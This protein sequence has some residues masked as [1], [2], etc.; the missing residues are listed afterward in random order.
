MTINNEKLSGNSALY[1]GGK[2]SN[3]SLYK[4][5]LVASISQ[6]VINSKLKNII[7]ASSDNTSHCYIHKGDTIV[8]DC[9]T[10]EREIHRTASTAGHQI[11]NPINFLFSIPNTA[12]QTSLQKKIADALVKHSSFV[13]AFRVKACKKIGASPVILLDQGTTNAIYNSFIKE[14]DI[15]VAIPEGQTSYRWI[16]KVYNLD[17][18][19]QVKIDIH[20][21]PYEILPL[22]PDNIKNKIKIDSIFSLQNLYLALNLLAIKSI[23]T[24]PK[25]DVSSDVYKVLEQFLYDTCFATLRKTIETEEDV[26]KSYPAQNLGDEIESI[27]TAPAPSSI[28]PTDISLLASPYYDGNGQP[29]TK[30]NWYTLNYLVM[31]DNHPMPKPTPFDWNWVEPSEETDYDAVLAIRGGALLKPLITLLD[32]QNVQIPLS[33][34]MVM[35]TIRYLAG[36]TFEEPSVRSVSPISWWVDDEVIK[37]DACGRMASKSFP[38]DPLNGSKM[39]DIQVEYQCRIYFLEN[40]IV[41]DEIVDVIGHVHIYDKEKESYI[42]IR[43]MSV[44]DPLAN[45]IL[46][47][48]YQMTITG[49]G[50]ININRVGNPDLSVYINEK[51][52]DI[53]LQSRLDS[54]ESTIFNSAGKFIPIGE[55]IAMIIP[56]INKSKELIFPGSKT[57]IFK[58]I[59]S[60]DNG[61]LLVYGIY[62]E[63][64]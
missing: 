12:Q 32:V 48:E 9:F 21:N 45:I 34:Y 10:I 5:D 40:K 25:S 63:E 62:T 6:K 42:D 4:Y 51:F 28:K 27:K 18:T 61:D 11:N 14:L 22:L 36:F 29:T 55:M 7:S 52:K 41:I 26:L 56:Y 30:Y 24:H 54:I 13:F 31:I 44:M 17:K 58:D 60:S 1:L 35:H 2:K 47:S 53:I 38:D 23:L 39:E 64:D 50:V 43:G 57:F 59:T 8:A 49:T 46:T 20:E 3:L 37:G 33:P 19:G 16:R 15:V